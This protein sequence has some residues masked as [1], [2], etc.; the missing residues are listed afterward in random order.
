[1]SVFAFNGDRLLLGGLVEA[2]VLGLYAIAV[3]IVG[4]IQSANS[5]FSSTVS[6]PTL[7][8]IAR[9][10]P[11]RLREVYYKL[12]VPV[13]LLLLSMA[14]LLAASGQL[15]IDLL[16]DSRYAETGVM[17]RILALSFLRCATKLRSR[18]TWRS[19]SRAILSV[20]N[21]VRCVAL[22]A[23]VPV[24]VLHRRHA[25]APSGASRCTRRRPCRSSST[26]NAKLG[27]NDFRRELLAL[28]ILPAG[29]LCGYALNLLWA[30]V[31]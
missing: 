1:M 20:I 21:V 16:Y 23:L 6:L 11:S 10:D 22:Y 26:F 19:A 17:L 28:L 15:V 12:R 18:S 4:A 3:L 14:G 29:Y 30:M 5:R 8:E 27:L 2:H 31:R 24:A 7:S 13:D 9:T 25:C